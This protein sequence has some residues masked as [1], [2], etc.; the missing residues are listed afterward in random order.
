MSLPSALTV[1]RPIL[2]AWMRVSRKRLPSGDHWRCCLNPPSRVRRTTR[3]EAVSPQ[4]HKGHKE[5][6]TS[7]EKVE[8][9]ARNR[10]PLCARGTSACLTLILLF[11]VPFVPLW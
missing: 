10:R 5:D 9:R 8:E 11:F 1:H 3:E 2:P 4:R 6:K 7:R